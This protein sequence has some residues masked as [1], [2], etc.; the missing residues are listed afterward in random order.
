MIFDKQSVIDH[1]SQVAGSDQV[2]QAM[3]NLPDQ[4][5]TEAHGQ[6]LQQL[7]VDPQQMASKLGGQIG[8]A[9]GQQDMGSQLG[10][11]VG[12]MFGGGQQQG[13]DPNQN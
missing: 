4:V 2:Q 3:Q 1:I 13:G 12:G 5:D 6:L 9:V 10:N 7:G 8:E 11:A